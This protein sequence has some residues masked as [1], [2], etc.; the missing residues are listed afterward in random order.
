VAPAQAR[1]RRKPDTLRHA[2]AQARKK[3]GVQRGDTCPPAKLRCE[4][5]TPWPRA[6]RGAPLAP[7]GALLFRPGRSE[8]R[9][10]RGWRTSPQSS[11]PKPRTGTWKEHALSPYLY[12]LL[13]LDPI[14]KACRPARKLPCSR[15]GHRAV[16]CRNILSA[17]PCAT[18]Q[19][20]R[21]GSSSLQLAA[22][23]YGTRARSGT[24]F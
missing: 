23:P 21:R 8:G 13:P 9:E 11:T 20:L 24:P 14:G 15:C 17:F 19:P 10:G 1:L 6:P 16:I 5:R 3:S 22:S 12:W 18:T 2:A 4:T 7:V